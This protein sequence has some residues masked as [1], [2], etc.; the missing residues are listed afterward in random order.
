MV[1]ASDTFGDVGA[2]FVALATFGLLLAAIWAGKTAK[3][4]VEVAGEGIRSQIEEQRRIERRRRTYELLGIYMSA[5]FLQR[6][7]DTVPVL[8]IFNRDRAAGEA[9][10]KQMTETG[11]VTVTSVLNFYELVATE[12][13]SGFLDRDV[14]D[15]HLAY[16]TIVM[17]E[18]AKGH[19]EW[20][21]AGNKRYY[22]QWKYLYDTR[23]AAIEASSGLPQMPEAPKAP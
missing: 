9:H 14:A 4:S 20:R 16:A 22:E 8:R 3:E 19:L 13:N 18:H 15:K 7:T 10:W 2:L 5:D 12:Y 1:L 11:K 6:S 17:W 23:R 21:R